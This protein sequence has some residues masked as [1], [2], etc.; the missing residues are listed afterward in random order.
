MNFSFKYL[1]L[2]TFGIIFVCSH[3]IDDCFCGIYFILQTQL[4]N[5]STLV[6][7]KFFDGNIFGYNYYEFSETFKKIFICIFW[8]IGIK[9]KKAKPKSDWLNGPIRAAKPAQLAPPSLSHRHAG[10]ACQALLP[11]RA[12]PSR[13]SRLHHVPCPT[14]PNRTI[15]R[16]APSHLPPSQK[17]TALP[18]PPQFTFPLM[19]WCHQW[20]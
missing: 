14:N 11:P 10:P 1:I 13:D 5:M 8:E 16:P 6:Q 12:A 3:L 17:R 2:F 18:L 9:E 15:A 19:N 4:I 7:N 20:L